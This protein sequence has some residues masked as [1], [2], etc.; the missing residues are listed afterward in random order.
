MFGGGSIQLVRISG[1]RIGASPSWFIVLFLVIYFLAGYFQDTLGGTQ[2]EGFVVAVCS[3]VLFFASLIAHELGHAFT[4]R[5]N[6]IEIE[7]IDLW[8]LGGLARFKQ[9]SR[10]PGQEFAIAAAGRRSACCSA[11]LFAGL[12]LAVAGS[13]NVDGRR[14][15]RNGV[16]VSAPLRS[17]SSSPR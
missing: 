11:L 15:L 7:G 17:S 6:G 4:A 5:R 1:I 12:S 13:D 14:F 16:D 10:S 8:L 2:T 3:A 9:D